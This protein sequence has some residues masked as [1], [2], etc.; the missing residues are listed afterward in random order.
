MKHALQTILCFAAWLIALAA[1]GNWIG[2]HA[3]GLF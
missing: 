3:R 1:A 2:Y